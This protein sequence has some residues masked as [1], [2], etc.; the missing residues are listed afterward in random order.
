M[1]ELNNTLEQ[2]VTERTRA[3]RASA[4]LL[5][6]AT[7]NAS[8]GLVTLDRDRRYAFANP[9]YCKIFGLPDDIIGKHPAE[10]LA[11]VYAEQVAPLLDRAFA[12]E[13]ISCELSVPAVAGLTGQIQPLFRRLRAG[14]RQ[15]GQ[16]L[17]AW[18]WSC[19]TSLIANGRRST[20]SC[21]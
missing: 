9:A 21:C 4:A 18:W 20:S 5:Q 15:R 7:D 10:L 1:R 13:R 19:S 3:L 8:V 6:T 14:T 12:G 17:S 16:L 2:R 11:P